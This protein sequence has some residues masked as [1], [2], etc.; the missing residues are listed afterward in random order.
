LINVS[1]AEAVKNKAAKFVDGCKE[2]EQHLYRFAPEDWWNSS[3]ANH[4]AKYVI[5]LCQYEWDVSLGIGNPELHYKLGSL[6]Y[7]SEN[8]RNLKQVHYWL[9]K[10]AEAGH[11]EACNALDFLDAS[12]MKFA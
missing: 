7:L 9:G 2:F 6:Y 5:L 12:G 3:D 11:Q 4:S 1:E 10:A 8:R